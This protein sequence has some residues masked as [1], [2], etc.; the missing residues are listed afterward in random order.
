[1]ERYK[2]AQEE[3]SEIEEKR[4]EQKLRKDSIDSF[5][6]KLRSQETILKAFDEAL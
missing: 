5:V 2:K 1:M 3:L 4:Q 6:D